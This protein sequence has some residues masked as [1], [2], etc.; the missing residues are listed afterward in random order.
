MKLRSWPRRV[1]S[2]PCDNPN[3]RQPGSRTDECRSQP[4]GGA[5]LYL[6]AQRISQRLPRLVETSSELVTTPALSGFTV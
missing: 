5:T 4:E 3:V 1:I 2:L 6:G